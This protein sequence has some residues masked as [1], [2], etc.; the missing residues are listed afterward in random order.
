MK[1]SE[2]TI[3]NLKPELKGKKYADGEGLFLYVTPKGAKSWRFRYR[4]F[5]GEEQEIIFGTYPVKG[6]QDARKERFEAR[7]LLQNGIDPKQHKKEK[8]LQARLSLANTLKEVAKEW[9]E[10]T[11][12]D[13]SD[14]HRNKVW[15]CLSKHVFHKV[16]NHPISSIDALMFLNEIIRPLERLG[17]TEIAHNVLNYCSNIMRFSVITKRIPYNPLA[18]LK[19]VLKPHRTQHFPAITIEEVPEFLNKLDNVHAPEQRKLAIRMLLLTFV[20]TKELRNAKWEQFDFD[21]KLWVIPKEIMK[22]KNEHIVP[23]SNQTLELLKR[24]KV[25]AHGSDYVFPSRNNIKSPFMHENAITDILKH[26]GMGYKGRMVGHGFRS[27]ASTTLNELGWYHPQIIEKQLA[28]EE[29]NKVKAAYNRAQYLPQRTELMQ[30]WADYIDS[31]VLEQE[32]KTK[33][34][35][36]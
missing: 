12:T 8:E 32:E 14:K 34:N 9:H 30:R 3:K 36:A 33:K 4:D 5:T 17:K 25:L 11:H 2:I 28:H 26:E 22:M 15:N 21:K 31:V 29:T 24:L 6:L 23:L 13:C 20:R 35:I 1:L 7:Q 16:G 27:L 10:I 19:G 18:D